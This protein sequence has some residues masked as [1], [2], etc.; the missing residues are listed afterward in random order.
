MTNRARGWVWAL[1]FSALVWFGLIWAFWPGPAAAQS[2]PNALLGWACKTSQPVGWC[3]VSD[4]NPAPV[5]GI[6]VAGT[7]A[8][9]VLTVQGVTS[10][11]PV[12][13]GCETDATGLCKAEDAVAVT[14]DSGVAMLGV[15][16]DGATGLAASGDYGIIGTD[17]AGNSRIVGSIASATTDSGN[18]LKI[19]GVHNTTP[20]TVTNGQRVD[21]QSDTNGNL[22]VNLAMGTSTG[23]D[24]IS[25]TSIVAQPTGKGSSTALGYM[26]T[27]ALL[28][29]GS[30]WDRTRSGGV[31]GMTGVNLQ[32]TTTGG[33][34]FLNIAAGQATTV[35]K[36]GAGTLYRI[37]LNSAATATNTTTI[38]D[39]TA[40][41][42]TVIGRPAVTTATLPTTLDYGD[43]GLAFATGLTIIT[44][45]ANGGDMTVI[46]K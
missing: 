30:T 24:A 32:A 36:S 25:N 33:A 1:A 17:T 22:R 2:A 18:P 13:V 23:A 28:Y 5:D 14:A 42:G 45:T 10:M 35:V 34:S 4:T 20:P 9:G 40:A 44:A 12:V 46:Y 15:V 7:P 39:N 19:G 43:V 38:Y 31:T 41:S 6:G 3:A 16:T 8:G 27:V 29:N 11:E 26:G 37:I 21:A